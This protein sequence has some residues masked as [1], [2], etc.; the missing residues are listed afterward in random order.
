MRSPRQASALQNNII[1][2]STYDIFSAP[3]ILHA[4]PARDWT[5][6]ESDAY[7]RWLLNIKPGR[8]S[9]L[10]AIAGAAESTP[11]D[12]RSLRI[13]NALRRSLDN[14]GDTLAVGRLRANGL[15]LAAG[16]D[17]ALAIGDELVKS[18]PLSRWR[19]MHTNDEHFISMNLTVVQRPGSS[20][21]FEPFLEGR[22]LLTLAARSG[23]DDSVN[24]VDEKFQSF[25]S[26]LTL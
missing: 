23:N 25:R 21:C 10:L 17:A 20:H 22:A 24:Y 26:R 2:L 18:V 11:W 15:G 7:M 1:S 5:A 12:H 4:K 14:L 9:Q 8:I 6:E 3:Q 16:F 19:V 13:S